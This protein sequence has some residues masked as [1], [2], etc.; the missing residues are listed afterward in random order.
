MKNICK[1]IL[2]FLLNA[3]LG[4]AW[5]GMLTLMTSAPVRIDVRT[6]QGAQI[7]T[8]TERVSPAANSA[9]PTS[10]SLAVDGT[11]AA[12]WSMASPNYDSTLKPDGWHSF[13]LTENGSAISKSLLVRNDGVV[14]HGGVLTASETWDDASV[15]VV[16]DWVR[17]PSGMTL[18]IA[19]GAVVK[20]CDGAGIVVDEGGLLLLQECVLT[21]LA[22]DS[23]GGDTNLDGTATSPVGNSYTLTI[24]GTVTIDGD[25]ELAYAKSCAK[26]PLY[27]LATN[28]CAA[29]RASHIAGATV[30]VEA[31]FPE[32]HSLEDYESIAWQS[33]VS[34]VTFTV[35]E[36]DLAAFTMPKAN[37]TVTC[38]L[39]EKT[40][41]VTAIGATA[42]KSEAVR[43]EAVTV[44]AN[45]PNGALASD[46]GIVWSSEPELEFE[47][48][49]ASMSFAMPAEAVTVTCVATLKTYAVKVAAGT[50]DK[51]TAA[52]G[53]TVAV[54]ATVASALVPED[55]TYEW[56]ATPSVAFSGNGQTATFAMP[57][58]DVAVG[59]AMTL[60]TYAV[61][62]TGAVADKA[63]AAR[64]EMVTMTVTLPEGALLSDYDLKW[65]SVPSVQFS[66]GEGS[67]TFAMPAEP[68]TVTC[69]ATLKYYDVSLTGATSKRARYAR[70]ETVTVMANLPSDV[71]NC[72]YEVTWS[73]TPALEFEEN[74]YSASFTMPAKAVSVSCT[75]AKLPGRI[76]VKGDCV[77]NKERAAAGETVVLTPQLLPGTVIS[78]YNVNWSSTPKVTFTATGKPDA[79]QMRFTMPGQNIEIT[80]INTLKTYTVQ[81]YN[82]TP[83]KTLAARGEVVTV[84]ATDTDF[85][86]MTTMMTWSGKPAVE[87]TKVDEYTATFVMPAERVIVS[88][89][90]RVRTWPITTEGCVANKAEASA[91]TKITVTAVLPEG[92]ELSD[93]SLAWVSEPALDFSVISDTMATFTMPSEAVNVT[94]VLMPT[95]Y[96]VTA[97]G[98]VADKGTASRGETV[99]VT[100]TLPEGALTSDYEFAWSSVPAVQFTEGEGIATFAMPAE[101]VNVTC[102]ATLKTYAVTATGAVADKSEAP[103][104]ETVTV[105]AALPEGALASDYEFAWSSTPEVQFIENEGTATFAM[106]A[107]AV[108]VTCVATLK[109]YAVTANGSVA[110]KAT[111]A[112]GETVTVTAIVPDGEEPELW[113]AVW[114]SEP[115]VEF[116]AADALN[117]TFAMPSEAVT[118]TCTLV[119]R[120]L[121]ETATRRV[122]RLRPGW[123]AVVLSLAPDDAS[124][125]KLRRLHAMA[126][127]ALNHIYVQAMEFSA[128]RLY[129]L[130][131]T[132]ARRVLV[133]GAAADG[134]ALP[135]AGGKEWQPY[136]AFPTTTLEGF[137]L[138]QWQE[139][140]F[141]LTQP[142]TAEPGRG[143]FVK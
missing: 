76:T 38:A 6:T 122:L 52:R 58:S 95:T 80:F 17:V 47:V 33:S 140:A 24:N 93:G 62:A 107:E 111:V 10:S 26:L 125:A 5:A 20:F 119:E 97:N 49:G 66:D 42:D 123:N 77:A 46:C 13:R 41:A 124:A 19:D 96:A 27:T 39:T 69:T 15:H 40:Y 128:D 121:E 71:A 136:G 113:E 67:A 82:C 70:G 139:G 53:E 36:E 3:G 63:I 89:V 102:V 81:P 23:R 92:M 90:K 54:T 98:A 142:P 129:W 43:G 35:V 34:G 134:P 100:A 44:T 143:Y 85:D 61:T 141:R 9:S 37:L 118:V 106:P 7:I 88:A 59:Y 4:E 14:V 51:S 91:G 12:G 101:A 73:F 132:E 65:S 110:D 127:D 50:A 114:S 133:T 135:S 87:F 115:T 18:T 60:K 138:W 2:V 21:H 22:D 120:E 8:G 130:Y 74:G 28:G 68:V 45:L 137:V 108:T 126:L 94:C 86:L 72:D 131:A 25:P 104:G 64:G 75:Y 84:R 30:A 16:R 55:Y 83:S 105:T 99:T 103:R 112:R 78:D 56:S 57:A 11:S 109:T 48:N 31:L 116:V 32:G 1:Y 117:A 29:N 79:G